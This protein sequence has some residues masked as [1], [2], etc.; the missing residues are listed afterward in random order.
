MN[1][2]IFISGPVT[3]I[4]DYKAN[5]KD[6]A[7]RIQ[8]ARWVCSKHQHC[9][10]SR[11]QFHSRNYLF[12]CTIHEPFPDFP[13]VVNPTTLGLDGK[14]WLWCMA[15]CVRHLLRCSYVFMLHGWQNS[16]GARIEHWLASLLHKQIIYQK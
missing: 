10:T 12:G 16:R 8:E 15:V 3:G 2:R 11:C 9:L 7:S 13:E 14:P 5:F 1:N 6:A 4:P